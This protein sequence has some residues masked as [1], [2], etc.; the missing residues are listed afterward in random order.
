MIAKFFQNMSLATAIAFMVLPAQVVFVSDAEARRGGGGGSFSRSSFRSSPS[1]ASR[2]S[3]S[4]RK[5]QSRKPATTQRASAPKRVKPATTFASTPRAAR[6][7]TAQTRARFQKKAPPVTPR[8][9]STA[10]Q[11]YSSNPAYTRA[12]SAN[13]ST[14]YQRRSSHYGT[15]NTPT[16]VYHSS[17]SYGMLDTIF[18]YHMLST[19]HSG[20]MGYH[21]QNN[22]DYRAWRADADKLAVE[23]AE[24]RTQLAAMDAGM[25]KQSG[26]IQEGFVPAGVD[27]DLMLSETAR[28]SLVPEFRACVAGKT[29]TYANVMVNVVNPGTSAVR[30]SIVPTSG[31]R[32]ILSNIAEGKC[33]GGLVQGDSYWNYIEFNETTELPFERVL[34]AYKESVHLMCN[35]DSVDAMDE[36]TSANTV[37][38]PA[39]SG[40]AETWDN[41]VGESDDY[42]DVKTTLVASYEEAAM[43]AANTKNSCALYVGATGS[44]ELMRKVE[45]GASGTKLVL[46]DAVDSDILDT[47]DPSD[48]RVYTTGSIDDATYPNLLREG[49]LGFFSG[50]VDTLQVNADFIIGTAWKAANKSSYDSFTLDLTGMQSDIRKGAVK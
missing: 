32:E 31:S 28:A 13:S 24:L 50:D 17:P 4:S 7:Q 29:G 2:P 39:N 22:A 44:S 42:A 18:L 45:Q 8:N 34:T 9:I 49:T 11:R 21:Y 5:A 36:L 27:A 41:L 37:F 25:A 1:K 43:K 20:S 26:P 23:N 30:V 40:A 15:W 38:F 10:G 12:R 46:V 16:Y 48:T 3:F 14:Y 19:P 47:T 6:Q 35:D 33:D